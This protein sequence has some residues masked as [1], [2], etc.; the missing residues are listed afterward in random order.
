MMLDIS[1]RLALFRWPAHGNN[2]QMSVLNALHVT[3]HLK[4]TV[5]FHPISFG[6]VNMDTAGPFP[7]AT[8]TPANI[9]QEGTSGILH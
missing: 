9:Y 5:S 4:G 3:G 2:R 6:G 1:A 8:G 7:A